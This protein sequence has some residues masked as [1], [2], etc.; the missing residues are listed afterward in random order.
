M[1][2]SVTARNKTIVEVCHEPND[3]RSMAG[4]PHI[5]IVDDDPKIRRGLAKFLVEQ[6]VRV[7]VA[8]DGREMDEKLAAANVDVVVLDLMMPGE[9]G[10]SLLRRL[11]A[12]TPIPVI[13]LTAVAGETDRVIGLELGA[14]DYVCK[15]F[16]PRELLARIRVV[17]RR[18]QQEHGTKHDRTATV[19]TFAGWRLDLRGR[20]L[21]APSG[22]HVELT[23]G[24]FELL[25]AFAEHPNRILT[26]DQ[27]LDLARGRASLSIDRAIDVQIMRLRRK[28]EADPQHPSVIKTVRNGGYIFTPEVRHDGKRES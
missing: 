12:D 3:N 10:L 1:F 20:T 27:L 18:T 7:T 24:E 2:W 19:L 17:L 26:R 8:A 5:L 13:L 14:E 28:I 22:A 15:P 25:Q 21:N 11:R 6:G 4:T 9:S 23:T 16:S